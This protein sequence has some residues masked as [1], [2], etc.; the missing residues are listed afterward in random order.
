[1]GMVPSP[2]PQKV[3]ILSSADLS[4]WSEANVDYRAVATRVMLAGAGG[5][6]WA[7]TD[8]GMIL[9]RTAEE[10]PL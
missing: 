4:N 2:V 3:R 9:T 6:V 1:M 7:A 5:S 10:L 8:T